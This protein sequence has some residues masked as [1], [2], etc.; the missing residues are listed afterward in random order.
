MR[1]PFN[2]LLFLIAFGSTAGLA[3][4]QTL[5]FVAPH[6]DPPVQKID[7]NAP[8]KFTKLK[9]APHDVYNNATKGS[10]T[11]SVTY[12]DVDMATGFGW[13][14]P[15]DGPTRRACLVAVLA[16]VDSVLDSPV[17]TT[18]DIDFS[19]SETDGSANGPT[20]AFAGTFFPSTAGVT[21]FFEGVMAEHVRTGIDPAGAGAIPD[22]FSTVD[23]GWTWNSD[24]TVSPAGGE[25]DLF[26]VLLHEITHG[27]GFSSLLDS[28]GVSLLNGISPGSFSVYNSFMEID[29]G[30]PVGSGPSTPLFD[31]SF[32]FVG[33]APGDL[34]S[35]AVVSTAPTAAAVLG[36]NPALYAP[37]TFTSG[38]SLSHWDL[39]TFPT[40]VMKPSV[41][42]G[43]MFRTYELFELGMLFDLGYTSVDV[44]TTPTFNFVTDSTGVFETDGSRTVSVHL[45]PPSLTGS[46]SVTY[47]TSAGTATAGVDYTDVTGML[48]WTMGESGT[49]TFSVP[50]A[51]D[52]PIENTETVTM[53]LSAPTGD[54]ILGTTSVSTL[55]IIDP[56]NLPLD[57]YVLLCVLL[58]A[59]LVAYRVRKKNSNPDIDH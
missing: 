53:T 4:G 30:G 58:A 54:G 22:I 52:V 18:I 16:Y 45:S 57:S 14:D 12:T 3:H 42:S 7:A 47:T 46:V 35:G 27:L 6:A 2:F 55:I 11:W 50:V 56:A 20:L 5:Y 43:T 33:T 26:T 59:A 40:S 41:S 25:I 13:D 23:F 51:V 39:A 36:S 15:T 28:T 24:H 8:G 31:G 19:L 29:D 10:I 1:L 17:P 44:T 9:S 49:K 32:A 38:S 34:T 48:T 37:G 21:G